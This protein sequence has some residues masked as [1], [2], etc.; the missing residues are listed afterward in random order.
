MTSQSGAFAAGEGDAWFARNKERLLAFDAEGDLALRLLR[1]FH[2]KPKRALEVGCANG[3]RLAALREEFGC[4]ALGTDLSAAAVQDGRER[5]GLQLHTMGA[6]ELDLP[7]TFELI[8]VHFVLHW[9]D[10]EEIASVVQ[11]LDKHLAPGGLLLIGDFHPNAPGKVAYHHRE[12]VELWTFKSDYPGLFLTR[13][14]YVQLGQLSA[15]HAE[16]EP[17]AGVAGSDR[18][19][20]WLLE[21]LDAHALGESVADAGE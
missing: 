7:G 1:L 3:A 15:D 12:D 16:F 10:R 14:N 4:E 11:A 18:V 13:G 17:R 2:V 8:V 5:F 6:G 21:K 19:A 20:V 9:I